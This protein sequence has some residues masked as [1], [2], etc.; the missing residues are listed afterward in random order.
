MFLPQVVKSARVMKQAVAY[1]DALHGGREAEAPATRAK[2]GKVL[3]AT[4]KGDVHDIGK[5][6]VGVVLGCNN[7]EV[8]DLGVMVPCEKILETAHARRRRHHRPVR[9]DH[10]VA[11]RD[12]PRRQGDAAR[13]AST[14]RCSSAARPPAAQHTAVKIAPEYAR[15]RRCT[16]S[17]PRARSASCVAARRAAEDRVRREEPRGAGDAARALRQ[18]TKKRPCL[19]RRGQRA[20]PAH[21]VE[22]RR[23]PD[24]G[25]HRRAQIDDQSPRRSCTIHRLDLLLHGLGAA[26][27]SSRRSSSTPSTARRRASC[28]TPAKK[29]LA[30]IVAEQARSRRAR[31]YGFWPAARRRQRHRPLQRTSAQRS[32]QHAAQQQASRRGGGTRRH[33]HRCLADFVA[34]DGER[35]CP[36]TSARSR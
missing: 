33:G 18:K 1:L 10:A 12:G 9:A 19:V 28:S 7:Y 26:R 25:V 31:V 22:R 4:V 13:R 6:I 11:R 20:R 34:P 17:T 32:R 30:R 5:N 36:I 24:A 16:C 35:R 27:A 21:R 29:L 14:C 3:L 8:I 23:H 15:R 2:R